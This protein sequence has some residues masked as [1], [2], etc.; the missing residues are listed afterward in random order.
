MFVPAH[1]LFVMWSIDA[2]ISIEMHRFACIFCSC[3]GLYT[4]V[5]ILLLD[6]SPLLSLLVSLF[7]CIMCNGEGY[8]LSKC[9]RNKSAVFWNSFSDKTSLLVTSCAQ[10]IH[11]AQATMSNVNEKDMVCMRK[12]GGGRR[13]NEDGDDEE[14]DGGAEIGI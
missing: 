3:I 2:G 12:E 1:F 9:L 6:D 7:F 4:V 13:N 14:E 5:T 11:I 8:T 10:N